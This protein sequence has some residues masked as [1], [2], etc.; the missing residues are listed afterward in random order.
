MIPLLDQAV[1]G[2]GLRAWPSAPREIAAN[3]L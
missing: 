2:G 1:W 3:K